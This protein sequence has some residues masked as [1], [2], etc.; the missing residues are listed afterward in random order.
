MSCRLVQEVSLQAYIAL[1]I[2]SS[3]ESLLDD[4]T[5]RHMAE[6]V[7]VGSRIR[8]S[9]HARRI[10][11]CK[12]LVMQKHTFFRLGSSCRKTRIVRC[13]RRMQERQSV[14]STEIFLTKQTSY[15]D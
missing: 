15:F 5:W 1:F 2:K 12:M 9:N 7:L 3:L 10:A 8:P 14:G 11:H 6:Q 13:L 4:T